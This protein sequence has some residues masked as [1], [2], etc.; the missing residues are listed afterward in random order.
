MKR[1]FKLPLRN[2]HQRDQRAFVTV[3]FVAGVGLLLVPTALFVMTLPTWFE[4][5]DM[6]QVAAR[7]AAREYVLTASQSQAQQTVATIQSNYHLPQDDLTL[8]SL[9]GNPTQRGAKVTATIHTEIP[10]LQIPIFGIEAPSIAIN[11][12]HSEMVDLYRSLP[13]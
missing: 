4:R 6:A 1:F 11:T 3:E 13:A 5:V 2:R 10:S 8:A 12:S 9:S 7:E